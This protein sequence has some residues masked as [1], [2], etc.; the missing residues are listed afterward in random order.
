MICTRFALFDRYEHAL[1]SLGDQ[2][3]SSFRGFIF[4]QLQIF[5]ILY[6]YISLKDKGNEERKWISPD[7]WH[8]SLP[9]VA[10]FLRKGSIFV[11]TLGYVLHHGAL[12]YENRGFKGDKRAI[13]IAF[14]LREMIRFYKIESASPNFELDQNCSSC[15]KCR[16]VNNYLTSWRS[17]CSCAVFTL[18]VLERAPSE[19]VNLLTRA[20]IVYYIQV[21]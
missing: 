11:F 15:H 7:A 14:Q 10:V 8:R 2:T 18:N 1:R 9:A 13:Y 6:C 17:I 4:N 20:Q 3:S 16:A 21:G 19:H 12:I 5:V